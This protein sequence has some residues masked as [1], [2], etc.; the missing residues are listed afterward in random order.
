MAAPSVQR[1]FKSIPRLFCWCP[2]DGKKYVN[3]LGYVCAYNM[4]KC[5]PDMH[6]SLSYPYDRAHILIER[7]SVGEFYLIA[8]Y[9]LFVIDNS[10]MRLAAVDWHLPR[11]RQAN[12]KCVLSGVF[13]CHHLIAKFV[14]ASLVSSHMQRWICDYYVPKA[15]AARSGQVGNSRIQ[16]INSMPLFRTRAQCWFYVIFVRFVCVCGGT[17]RAHDVHL[18]IS[19]YVN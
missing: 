17:V 15:T 13:V 3:P 18:F 7:H 2:G 4:C 8:N 6:V 10:A 14:A 5:V 9:H 19:I 12:D 11:V 1:C 16:L